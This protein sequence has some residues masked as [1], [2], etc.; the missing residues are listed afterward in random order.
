MYDKQSIFDGIPYNTTFFDI[1]GGVSYTEW[2]EQKVTSEQLISNV[3]SK[4]KIWIDTLEDIK[5][6]LGI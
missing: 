6:N 1:I 3:N 2:K 4:F 5:N